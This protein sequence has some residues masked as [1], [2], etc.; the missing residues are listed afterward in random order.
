MTTNLKTDLQAVFADIQN[1]LSQG[2]AM[3][4]FEKY[5]ADNVVMQE[6]NAPA[7]VGKEANRARELDFFNNVVEFR[8]AELKGVAF[9]DDLIISEWD[10]DYTHKEWGSLTYTQVAVQRWQDGKVVHERFY[11]NN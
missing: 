8:K 1:L 3:D 7:T 11:Y 6:N 4:I 5:Y 9:G 2:K 10:L